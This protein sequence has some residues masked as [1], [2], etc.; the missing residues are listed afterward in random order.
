MKDRIYKD[1]PV[2]ESIFSDEYWRVLYE[3][4]LKE[5]LQN[6]IKAIQV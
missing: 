6:E 4:G 2:D 3:M 1:Y 5:S